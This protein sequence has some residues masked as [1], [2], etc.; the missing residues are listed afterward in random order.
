MYG[1]HL[2]LEILSKVMLMIRTNKSYKTKI[3]DHTCMTY[4]Q[5][6]F[7]FTQSAGRLS[8][9]SVFPFVLPGEVQEMLW[10]RK[11]SPAATRSLFCCGWVHDLCR[12]QCVALPLSLPSTS[13]YATVQKND[14]VSWIWFSRELQG[15]VYEWSWW[16]FA[17]FCEWTSDGMSHHI[18]LAK[19]L[20]D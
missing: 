19:W 11:N 16:T 9:S 5:N 2:T 15:I 13:A 10:L 4:A 1:Y 6:R 12:S 20:V 18:Y 7:F 8:L 14:R 17:D 3:R